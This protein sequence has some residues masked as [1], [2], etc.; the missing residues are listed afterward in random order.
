LMVDRKRTWFF[1]LNQSMDK[2][3]KQHIKLELREK[4]R[5]LCYEY[6]NAISLE[7]AGAQYVAIWCWWYSSG[8]INEARFQEL[9]DWLSF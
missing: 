9:E 2:H 4:H 7:E 5:T 1:H 3:T 8:T 6:K